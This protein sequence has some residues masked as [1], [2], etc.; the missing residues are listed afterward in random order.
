[1][2]SREHLSDRQFYCHYCATYIRGFKVI[3][4]IDWSEH[5]QTQKKIYY[6]IAI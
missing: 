2:L 6:N 3:L 1:M 4:S 5:N